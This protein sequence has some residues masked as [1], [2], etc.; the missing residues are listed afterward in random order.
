MSLR[1]YKTLVVVSMIADAAM[2]SFITDDHNDDEPVHESEA[3]AGRRRGKTR[4]KTNEVGDV[5]VAT[6]ECVS[7]VMRTWESK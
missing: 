4:C 7:M 5:V 2:E 1:D 3:K 6:G